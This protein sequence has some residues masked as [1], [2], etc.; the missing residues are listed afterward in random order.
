M[1]VLLIPAASCS[2]GHTISTAP[3]ERGVHHQITAS[4]VRLLSV[5][6][7]PL[8]CS[9]PGLRPAVL[10]CHSRCLALQTLAYTPPSVLV[11]E[12]RVIDIFSRKGK[13]AGAVTGQGRH[14]QEWS[15]C[16]G[17][18]HHR[19]RTIEDIESAPTPVTL[20]TIL[21]HPSTPPAS[22][23]LTAWMLV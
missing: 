4:P 6:F 13:C 5:F 21:I 22:L 8:F 3:P 1:S 15:V 2:Y 17:D 19:P 7:S 14:M 9:V 10:L 16:V 11:L 23:S 12:S 20:T 18:D